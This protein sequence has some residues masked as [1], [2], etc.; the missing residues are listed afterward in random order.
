MGLESAIILGVVIAA[1]LITA[2][3]RND[4]LEHVSLGLAISLIGA[5]IC[6][7]IIGD[8]APMVAFMGVAVLIIHRWHHPIAAVIMLIYG[9]RCVW[10]FAEY[11]SPM[12]GNLFWTVNNY[13]VL[14]QALIAI[15]GGAIH[16]GL[17]IRGRKNIINDSFNR[18]C[19][20]C[21]LSGWLHLRRH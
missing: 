15:Y 7:Q 17:R 3:S 20:A 4:G 6:G 13:L 18:L 19:M 16:G 8:T 14:S 2:F 11:L 21:D 12:A 1:I 5:L 10:V 9:L